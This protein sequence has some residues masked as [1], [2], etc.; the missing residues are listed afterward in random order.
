MFKVFKKGEKRIDDFLPENLKLGSYLKFDGLEFSNMGTK[1]KFIFEAEGI[2]IE[3]MGSATLEGKKLINLYLGGIEDQEAYLQLKYD[4]DEI[5]DIKLFVNYD[6]I[7]PESDQEWIYWLGKDKLQG[8]I[9]DETFII[10][11]EAVEKIGRILFK[12][13]SSY[14]KEIH[15]L[16]DV[17][18][19]EEDS[20]IRTNIIEKIAELNNKSYEEVKTHFKEKLEDEEWLLDI[21]Q[22]EE[23]T[24][25][26]Y[27]FT[28]EDL[29]TEYF[30]LYE[31]G[32][33]FRYKE[34]RYS[35]N[36]DKN[37]FEKKVYEKRSAIYSR[38]IED[39]F[40]DEEFILVNYLTKKDKR[41]IALDLGISLTLNSI[42][43]V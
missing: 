26:Y 14:Y 39:E 40:F 34:K 27:T 41:I 28:E 17:D 9:G 12:V 18:F 11:D 20:Y 22:Y 2:Y 21:Q 43:K 42:K 5:E 38:D 8:I 3:K 24:D 29:Q 30:N 36:Q 13:A 33:N 25:F 32:K 19:F 16:E 35:Y 10:D 6:Y 15:N 37:D 4:K 23:M 31:K 7:Y 1:S